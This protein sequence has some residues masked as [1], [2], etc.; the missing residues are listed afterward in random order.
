MAIIGCAAP[1]RYCQHQIGNSTHIAA[2]QRTTNPANE[3]KTNMSSRVMFRF[4]Q[5]DVGLAAKCGYP[6]ALMPY[7]NNPRAVLLSRANDLVFRAKVSTIPS[8]A[9]AAQRREPISRA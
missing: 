5:M 1:E 3:S 9:P 6:T 4:C 7:L 2:M 8:R